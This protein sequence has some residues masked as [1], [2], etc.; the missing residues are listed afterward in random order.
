MITTKT[1]SGTTTTVNANA[2]KT[3]GYGLSL[4]ADNALFVAD[5]RFEISSRGT[6]RSFSRTSN[7]CRL[8]NYVL[9][10]TDYGG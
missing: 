6:L 2:I 10:T 9:S 1:K 4:K 7:N 8:V 5:S 3:K